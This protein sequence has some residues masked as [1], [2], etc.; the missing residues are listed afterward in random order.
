MLCLLLYCILLLRCKPLCS[1][2]NLQKKKW[3]LVK[4]SV[5]FWAWLVENMLSSILEMVWIAVL[6]PSICSRYS[7]EGKGGRFVSVA[8]LVVFVCV[9][10]PKL[11]EFLKLKDLYDSIIL[12]AF[13]STRVGIYDF[14]FILMPRIYQVICTGKGVHAFC[15]KK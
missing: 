11:E 14:L 15:N 4:G 2:L 7:L 5:M 3:N 8:R 10:D 1:L 9:S 12:I 6:C 13:W